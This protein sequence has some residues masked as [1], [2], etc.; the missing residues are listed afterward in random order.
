M[1]MIISRQYRYILINSIRNKIKRVVYLLF[2]VLALPD[3][4]AIILKCFF[5]CLFSGE[6]RNSRNV[7]MHFICQSVTGTHPSMGVEN[8]N[9][10]LIRP[11]TCDSACH[12]PYDGDVSF[13]CVPLKMQRM[14]QQNAI[15]QALTIFKNR[16]WSISS[17]N[18]QTGKKKNRVHVDRLQCFSQNRHPFLFL[19]LPDI[20]RW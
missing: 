20:S 15:I 18:W 6:R 1:I 5:V 7:R 2:S 11:Q 17:Y 13:V 3:L 9:S 16:V 19:L 14:F 8:R 12:F 10:C 4:Q